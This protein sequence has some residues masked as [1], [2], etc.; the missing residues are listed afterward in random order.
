M[1]LGDLGN[2]GMVLPRCL[3]ENDE[4][5]NSTGCETCA[6][7][8]NSKWWSEMSWGGI[9]AIDTIW[10]STHIT[11]WG[12]ISHEISG[13][14]D[15]FNMGNYEAGGIPCGKLRER[16]DSEFKY[17]DLGPQGVTV[18]ITDPDSMGKGG[19]NVSDQLRGEAGRDGYRVGGRTN[20]RRDAEWG[21]VGHPH[22]QIRTI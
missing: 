1:S 15:E 14:Y 17:E 2:R 8:G 12:K 22:P 6:I 3:G 10:R 9:F 21:A 16:A 19:D 13:T 4:P 11:L 7:M 18:G 20:L 5:R